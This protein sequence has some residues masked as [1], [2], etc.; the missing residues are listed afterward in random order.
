M[1]TAQAAGKNEGGRGEKTTRR[2]AV[3]LADLQLE[4]KLGGASHMADFAWATAPLNDV[5]APVCAAAGYVLVVLVH[6]R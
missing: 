3:E 1:G 5:R 6:P 2:R 4:D